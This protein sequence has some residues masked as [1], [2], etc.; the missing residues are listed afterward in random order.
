MKQVL[1]TPAK[2]RPPLDNNSF[3]L[4]DHYTIEELAFVWPT[5][6]HVIKKGDAQ[7]TKNAPESQWCSFI[8]APILDLIHQHHCDV[9][10]DPQLEV[11]D[12]S[13]TFIDPIDLCPFHDSSEVWRVLNKRIDFGIGLNISY[14]QRTTLTKG[15][16][17]YNHPQKL[18]TS[19]NQTSSWANYVPIFLNIEVKRKHVPVDPMIQLGAW[20]AAE[21][22][23]RELEGYD[24]H[25]P[26]F[27]IELEEDTWNLYI[28]YVTRFPPNHLV[29][30]GPESMGDTKSHQG[31]FKILHVLNGLAEWAK[32]EYR[33]WFERE[34]LKRHQ[35]GQQFT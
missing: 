34:V 7:R 25:M 10:G 4:T 5:V 2:S 11:L 29:F 35:S 9:G 8:V 31:V 23:K 18:G 20:V 21:F 13:T 32:T 12:M 16:Y 14:E 27:A 1:D 24:V 33:A 15:N 26:V 3:A 30:M 17:R 28:V 19:I 6:C 22:K